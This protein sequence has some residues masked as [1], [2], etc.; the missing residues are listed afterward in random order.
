[1]S[2]CYSTGSLLFDNVGRSKNFQAYSFKYMYTIPLWILQFLQVMWFYTIFEGTLWCLW[3]LVPQTQQHTGSKLS[4][5]IHERVVAYILA[6]TEN[7]WRLVSLQRT[8]PIERLCC[9]EY[10]DL[11]VYLH[12]SLWCINGQNRLR[13][14]FFSCRFSNIMALICYELFQNNGR[15]DYYTL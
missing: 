11:P 12:C 7:P 2:D 1:M 15:L 3:F 8:E 13:S 6:E 10:L 4:T 5:C 9:Y 14:F